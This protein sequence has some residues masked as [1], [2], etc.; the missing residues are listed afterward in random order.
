MADYPSLTLTGKAISASYHNILQFS[1]SNL[2]VKADGDLFQNLSNFLT[3]AS[4]ISSASYSNSSS[5]SISASYA[6]GSPTV[7]ASWASQSLSSSYGGNFTVNNLSFNQLTQS[8]VDTSSIDFGVGGVRTMTITG[9]TYF[10][11]S[12]LSA[13]KSIEM[14]LVASGGSYSLF[15]P[16]DYIWLNST[17]STQLTSGKTAIVSLTS[18]GTTESDVVVAWGSQL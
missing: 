12:N 15:W 3:T 8:Y 9:S 5:I 10:T 4:V 1:G 14:K 16:T 2:I 6:P 13:G 11:S 18:F 17:A 7:S